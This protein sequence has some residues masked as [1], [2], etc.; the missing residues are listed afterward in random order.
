MFPMVADS[1]AAG[2]LLAGA[3]A[4]LEGNSLY[5][6]VFRPTWSMLLLTGILF[7]NRYMA[8]TAIDRI[9]G[10]SIVNVGIAILIHRCVYTPNDW[11]GRFLNWRPVAFVGILSYSIYLWQELFTRRS[12]AWMEHFPQ[13]LLFI[14]MAALA[15]YVVLEKPFLRLRRKILAERRSSTTSEIVEVP[16]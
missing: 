8:Y 1:L 5:L 4:R 2:C 3:R 7:L 12:N 9:F 10:M 15:S 6:I 14:G 16:G 11:V 13:D